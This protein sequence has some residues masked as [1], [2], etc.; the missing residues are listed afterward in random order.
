MKRRYFKPYICDTVLF[1]K[2]RAADLNNMLRNFTKSTVQYSHGSRITTIIRRQQ[3]CI[4]L[5]F[6][7]SSFNT[8]ITAL[9]GG[10][11]ERF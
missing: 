8:A 7:D 9:F 2:I 1:K 11:K 6:Q 4:N 10:G 3:P 5:L